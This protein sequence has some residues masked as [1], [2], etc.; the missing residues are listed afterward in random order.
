MIFISVFFGFY[1][2]F[3]PLVLASFQLKEKLPV[4]HDPIKSVHIM[5]SIMTSQL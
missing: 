4:Q 1:S 2:Y 3:A 5:F